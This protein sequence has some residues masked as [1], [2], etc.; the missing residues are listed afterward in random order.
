MI[1]E[2]REYGAQLRLI[3]LVGIVAYLIYGLTDI[4]WTSVVSALPTHPLFYVTS[5]LI[6]AVL[7]LV[8]RLVFRRLLPNEQAVPI[9]VF[10]RKRVL[11][12][13]VLSYSGEAYLLERLRALSV[14]RDP[15]IAAIRDNA[16][17]SA[18]I[19]NTV[20]IGLVL[21]LLLAGRPDTIMELYRAAPG[22]AISFLVFAFIVYFIVIAM[23]RRITRLCR[24]DFQSLA[25]LHSLKILAVMSL[26]V[27]QW[28]VAL[29]GEPMGTWLT[30]LT[31]YM[32]V[33]RLPF[34]PNVDLVFLGVGI[35]LSG[36]SIHGAEALSGMLLA[37]A[38]AMQLL[39]V[40]AFVLTRDN[41]PAMR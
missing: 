10:I 11:N 30:F 27:T 35:S 4:G 5:L 3:L 22:A 39:H 40:V 25:G 7:P 21:L 14:A 13:G 37:S 23:F 16:I 29:P 17:V 41:R 9:G 38:V 2:I 1:S 31:I 19:S 15:A 26:Q 12:E 32:L 36:F 8:E 6:F 28:S 34:L 18:L 20:T 24:G 33:R